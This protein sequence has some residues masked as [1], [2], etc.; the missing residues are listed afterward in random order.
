VLI[1]AV[2]SAVIGLFVLGP[3]VLKLVYSILNSRT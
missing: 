1:S 2:G 3:H